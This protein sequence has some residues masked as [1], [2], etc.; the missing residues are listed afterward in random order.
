M[1]VVTPGSR[2]RLCL[3]AYSGSQTVMQ[4]WCKD[5]A[6]T[7]RKDADWVGEIESLTAARIFLADGE[8]EQEVDSWPRRPFG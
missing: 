7:D 6:A 8:T 2:G 3:T 4:S 5:R 1:D